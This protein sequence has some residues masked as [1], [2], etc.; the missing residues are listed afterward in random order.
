V[1]TY[2][3]LFRGINVGGSSILPMKD[4]AAILEGMGFA[5]VRTYIQSGNAVFSSPPLDKDRAVRE[6]RAVILEAHGL[7]PA[8]MLL[9]AD[10]LQ[11]AAANNPFDV[12]DGKALHLFFLESLPT[13]PDLAGLEAVRA[14]TE[15]FELRGKVFY[16]Y[17]PDGI[18]RSRLAAR[19][20]H[21]LGVPVTARNWNTVSKLLSMVAG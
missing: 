1:K 10:E 8:V 15:R 4:L 19:V 12:A 11:A 2:I 20:E 14:G 7:A 9:G 5:G 13:N 21:S 17:A 6:I 16:L 18:G 3:A